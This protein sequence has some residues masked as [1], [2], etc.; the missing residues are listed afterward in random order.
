MVL[1]LCACEK[2]NYKDHL[3]FTIFQ[4]HKAEQ[5][6]HLQ[7]YATKI[8]PLIFKKVKRLQDTSLI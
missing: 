5:T 4:T 1:D 6:L 7:I 8:P 3:F 2:E